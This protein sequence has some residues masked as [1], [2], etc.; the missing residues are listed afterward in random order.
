MSDKYSPETRLCNRLHNYL[1]VN[2]FTILQLICPGSQATI[3]VTYT[4]EDK[5]KKTLFPDL[6]AV[7]DATIVIGEIK[8]NFSR[9]DKKKLL[10]IKYSSDG[11]RKLRELIMRVFKIDVSSFSVSYYLVHG[12]KVVADNS[13]ISQLVLPGWA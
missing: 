7:K 11:E 5:V 3:S 9:S 2:N 1:L 6:I 4:T 10:S 12:G 13:E 8:P